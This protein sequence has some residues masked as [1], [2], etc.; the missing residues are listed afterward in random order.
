MTETLSNASVSFWNLNDQ[1]VAAEVPGAVHADWAEDLIALAFPT[2]FH[3]RFHNH[4]WAASTATKGHFTD[5]THSLRRRCGWHSFSVSGRRGRRGKASEGVV[6]AARAAATN[7]PLSYTLILLF[8]AVLRRCY[9]GWHRGCRC[10]CPRVQSVRLTLACIAHAAAIPSRR[11][12][13]TVSPHHFAAIYAQLLASAAEPV[14]ACRAC[15]PIDAL[16]LRR[17]KKRRMPRGDVCLPL[18]CLLKESN[19]QFHGPL[20]QHRSRARASA[21]RNHNNAFQP[22]ELRRAVINRGQSCSARGL[23]KHAVVVEESVAG[24]DSGSVGDSDASRGVRAAKLPGFVGDFFGAK[25][26]SDAGDGRQSDVLPLEDCTAHAVATDGFNS[27]DR[28]V[29]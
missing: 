26:G 18:T 28:N 2:Q 13:E 16:P 22:L 23:D 10:C 25:S 14:S 20:P 24:A 7:I 19:A 15:R 21:A 11:C 5:H 27:N 4:A 1:M 17:G 12:G 9:R 6:M 3:I 29:R 8:G